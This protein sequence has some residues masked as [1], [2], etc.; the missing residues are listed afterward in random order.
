MLI[1]D[2]IILVILFGFIVWGW[3]TGLI[4]AVAVLIGVVL[5]IIVAGR[6]YAIV[7]DFVLPYLKYNQNFAK[8]VGYLAVFAA[9]NLV[10]MLIVSVITGLLK[11]IPL[12]TTVNRLAGAL[13]AFVGGVLAI[14]FILLILSSVPFSDFLSRYTENSILIPIVMDIFNFISPLVPK[15][16]DELTATLKNRLQLL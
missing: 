1:I 13:V 7:A 12:M 15:A 16:I 9:V 14:G 5:G 4:K 11:L 2:I 8:I 3:Q 6:Y 10:I